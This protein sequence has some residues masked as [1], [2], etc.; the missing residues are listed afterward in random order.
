MVERLNLGEKEMDGTVDMEH[1]L[2]LDGAF[3]EL[4]E[5]ISKKSQKVFLVMMHTSGDSKCLL[6]FLKW[7]NP[8]Q[9]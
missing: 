9:I 4:F 8:R 6:Y 1:Q 7:L 2:D 5:I 3:M